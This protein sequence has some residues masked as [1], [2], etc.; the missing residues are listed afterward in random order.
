MILSQICD[1]QSVIERSVIR[2]FLHIIQQ[3]SPHCAVTYL[4]VQL[5]QTLAKILLYPY[6][7][8]TMHH[9]PHHLEEGSGRW[10]YSAWLCPCILCL[11]R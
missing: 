2:P 4:L 7:H 1:L 6:L 10:S 8:A 9:Y 5:R 11:L 3:P